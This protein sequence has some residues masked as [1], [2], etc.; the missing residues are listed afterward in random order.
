MVGCASCV[1]EESRVMLLSEMFF[2]NVI[3]ATS[4]VAIVVI[5]VI[6][7][8]VVALSPACSVAE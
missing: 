8:I 6:V 3:T 5:A 1:S 7:A 4:I 2:C